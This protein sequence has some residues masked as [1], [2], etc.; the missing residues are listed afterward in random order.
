MELKNKYID[1][2]SIEEA[3]LELPST[4]N[5]LTD[6]YN[7]RLFTC[8][9]PINSVSDY[10]NFK[11]NK[12]H[13]W[14]WISY[15]FNELNYFWIVFTKSVITVYFLPKNITEDPRKWDKFWKKMRDA[16]CSR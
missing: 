10:I 9:T 12:E 8:E 13:Y 16:D 11:T 5:K 4:I 6:K 15:G 1:F 3:M 7:F 2:N 14:G